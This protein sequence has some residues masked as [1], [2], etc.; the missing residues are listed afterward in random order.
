MAVKNYN[1]HQITNYDLNDTPMETKSILVPKRNNMPPYNIYFDY[2]TID[3]KTAVSIDTITNNFIIKLGYCCSPNGI[4]YP[5][6]LRFLGSEEWFE[7]QIGKEGMFE[8]QPEQW[9]NINL[10][11]PV[12][13]TSNI[14]VT[15]VQVPANINFTL[16]YVTPM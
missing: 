1:I 13:K 7:F 4:I 11:I 3:Y 14:E 10:E 8:F 12:V 9:K 2:E 16:E 5:I 15:G 6:F